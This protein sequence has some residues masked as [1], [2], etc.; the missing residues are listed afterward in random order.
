M[1]K[2][3]HRDGGLLAELFV[4]L[5]LAFLIGI[6]TLIYNFGYS[7]GKFKYKIELT[8][9]FMKIPEI[10]ADNIMACLKRT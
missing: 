2:Y 6:T 8:S 10:T 1:S 5:I 7:E 3:K 9:C 4:A